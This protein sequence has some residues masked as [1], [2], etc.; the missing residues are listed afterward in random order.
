MRKGF[1]EGPQHPLR[2]ALRHA[3]LL[4]DLAEPPEWR[5]AARSAS[6]KSSMAFEYD[7]L[8][9]RADGA[10]EPDAAARESFL[11]APLM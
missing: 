10:A 11:Q 6:R 3:E 2:G 7:M 1:G 8:P 5:A 4:D 9:L